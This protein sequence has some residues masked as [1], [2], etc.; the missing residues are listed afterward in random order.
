MKTAF[1]RFIELEGSQAR[2]AKRLGISESMV[3]RI[4]SGKRKLK[5]EQAAYICELYKEIS[6]SALLLPEKSAA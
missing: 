5:P 4:Q 1:T 2:A 6:F 3:S